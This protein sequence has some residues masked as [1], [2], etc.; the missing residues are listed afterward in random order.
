MFEISKPRLP[1]V[2]LLPLLLH[3]N[4]VLSFNAGKHIIVKL[5]LKLLFGFLEMDLKVISQL[6]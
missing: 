6:S 5:K 1:V 2:F 4:K 3:L